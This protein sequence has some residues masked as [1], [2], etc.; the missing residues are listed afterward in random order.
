MVFFTSVSLVCFECFSCFILMLQV[1]HLDV[2]KVYGVVDS[3]FQMHISFVLS[4]FRHMLQTLYSDV[5]SLSLL[6]LLPHLHLV[7]LPSPFGTDWASI[8]TS[9]LLGC[10]LSHLSIVTCCSC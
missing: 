1:F 3:V 10:W 5:A 4:T 8:A 9:P 2:S 7:S 6:F